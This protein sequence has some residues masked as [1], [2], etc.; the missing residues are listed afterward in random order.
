MT[1]KKITDKAKDTAEYIEA[2][3]SYI[4][5][6]LGYL[7]SVSNDPTGGREGTD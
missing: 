1:R 5:D 2:S 4:Y 3:K 6:V 7:Y